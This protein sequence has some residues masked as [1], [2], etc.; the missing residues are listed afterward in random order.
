[1]KFLLDLY[2]VK[3]EWNIE[4]SLGGNVGVLRYLDICCFVGLLYGFFVK[5]FYFILGFYN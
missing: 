3:Y 1:M 4:K 2:E 5:F